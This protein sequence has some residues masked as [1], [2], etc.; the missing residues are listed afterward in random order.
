MPLTCRM[1]YVFHHWLGFQ[2]DGASRG[3]I[4]DGPPPVAVDADWYGIDQYLYYTINGYW[5]A[6]LRFEWFRDEEGT[7]VGLNRARNPNVPPFPGSFYSL[8]F[9]ADWAPTDNLIVRPELRA[10][11]YD[12]NA[13]RLPYNDGTDSTQFMV[14]CDAILRF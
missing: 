4:I 3:G 11:W 6:G 10:D 2:E 1:D 7:R 14:G 8:S 13:A 9:G 12:G 5:K